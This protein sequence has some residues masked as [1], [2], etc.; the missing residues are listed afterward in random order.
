M[1]KVRLC[2]KI[3]FYDKVLPLKK[4]KKKRKKRKGTRILEHSKGNDAWSWSSFA[5]L[6]L[7][8]V[9]I[10]TKNTTGGFEFFCLFP[11]LGCVDAQNA[12]QPRVKEERSWHV[13]RKNLVV[14][15]G[16]EV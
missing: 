9:R 1:T 10:K 3:R 4:K 15:G 7:E 13:Y 14:N 2:W 11:F 16:R 5:V 12:E 6:E 8:P